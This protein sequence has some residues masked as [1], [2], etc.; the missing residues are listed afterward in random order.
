[1]VRVRAASSARS[2]AWSAMRA[3]ASS[4]GRAV[5]R[6]SAA[7]SMSPAGTSGRAG[8][9]ADRTTPPAMTASSSA[10]TSVSVSPS[11]TAISAPTAPSVATIGA[12]IETLPMVRALYV[13]VQPGRVAEAG[14]HDERQDPGLDLA[15]DAGR[16]RERE[17]DDRADDHHPREHDPGSDHPARPGGGQ[18]RGRPQDGGGEATK[19]RGHTPQCG[20]RAFARRAAGP[21]AGRGRGPARRPRQPGRRRWMTEGRGE[22]HH[23]RAARPGR[24]PRAARPLG[25][26]SPGR[27]GSPC[28]RVG[29]SPP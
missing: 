23:Q 6:P 12:T 11:A 1:M 2:T 5:E 8:S 25:S 4:R 22:Q 18:G 9:M 29:H 15:R 24:P 20:G 28:G 3:R 27:R 13:S 10:A 21:S 17:T 7:S 16:E 19:D 14:Q 26:A